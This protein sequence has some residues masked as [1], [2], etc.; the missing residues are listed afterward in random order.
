MARVGVRDVRGSLATWVRRAQ[1]GERI[2]VTVDGLPV[3][4][5]APLTPDVADATIADL[6]ARGSVTAPRR[7][8][9]WVP[10][11]PV[12]VRAGSRLDRVLHEVRG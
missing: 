2:I 10:G 11:D 3:A 7:R 9:G 1:A 12:P 4:Q 5:L 8:Q 6:I